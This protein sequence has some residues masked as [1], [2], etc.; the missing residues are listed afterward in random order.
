MYLFPC[1]EVG[2]GPMMSHDIFS[3]GRVTAF[4]PNVA[5][6]LGCGGLCFGTA[7]IVSPNMWYLFHTQA[8][9]I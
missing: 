7:H 3:K 4:V 9:K 6:G 1:K 8:S 5:T 2:R